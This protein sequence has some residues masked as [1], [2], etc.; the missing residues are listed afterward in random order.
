MKNKPFHRR[1]GFALVGIAE[2]WHNERSF[3]TH[4]F[5]AVAV[6][7]TLCILRPAPVWWAIILLTIALVLSAELVNAAFEGLID[8]LHPE[9][10]PRIRIV[11]D[12]AAGAVLIAAIA[13]LLIAGTLAIDLGWLL[14]LR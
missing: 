12:M 7:A 2:G 1:L 10:H 11:K 5:S 13:A 4:V 3:R 6:I 8:H 9:I 14:P